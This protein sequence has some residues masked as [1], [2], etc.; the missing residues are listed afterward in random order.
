VSLE[1]DPGD[2]ARLLA[3]VSNG[4]ADATSGLYISTDAGVS[5]TKISGAAHWANPDRIVRCDDIAPGYCYA[6]DGYVSSDGGV[7]WSADAMYD[8]T[9]ERVSVRPDGGGYRIVTSGGDLALQATASMSAASW[10]TVYTFTGKTAYRRRKIVAA[11]GANVAALVGGHLYVSSDSAATFTKLSHAVPTT[12][13]ALSWIAGSGST[14]YAA[15]SRWAFF[16]SVDAGATWNRSYVAT[17]ADSTPPAIQVHPADANRVYAYPENFNSNYSQ[18]RVVSSDGL[19]TASEPTANGVYSWHEGYAINPND[20]STL[21]GFGMSARTSSNFGLTFTTQPGS[22]T[23]VASYFPLSFVNPGNTDIAWLGMSTYGG[24][25]QYLYEVNL[26]SGATTHIASRLTGVIGSL[27]GH[28]LYYNGSAWVYRAISKTGRIAT[29]TDEVATFADSGNTGAAL[30]SCAPRI[31]TSL[32]SDRSVLATGC[33]AAGNR[34]AT[35]RDGGATWTEVVTCT[36]RSFVQLDTKV[37]VACKDKPIVS[38][39]Y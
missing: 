8:V 35:S 30:T 28:E 23:N 19:A 37:F 26:T 3:L 33:F 29:S 39:P 7:T 14:L 1:S 25:T 36:F 9:P 4:T 5:F 20:T 38:I 2:P 6:N 32:A 11:A 15:D 13:A 17:V 18:Y 12:Y 22:Y 21:V 10:S 24:G 27:A 34:I 16:K 31:L